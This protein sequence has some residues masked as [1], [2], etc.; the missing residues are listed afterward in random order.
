VVQGRVGIEHHPA[1]DGRLIRPATAIAI[2]AMAML[3]ASGCSSGGDGGGGDGDDAGSPDP[4]ASKSET[5]YEAG[6]IRGRVAGLDVDAEVTLCGARPAPPDERPY[7]TLQVDAEGTDADG[8]S[9]SIQVVQTVLDV[10]NAVVETIS[11]RWGEITWEAQRVHDNDTGEVHDLHGDG[12]TPLL[13]IDESDDA[14]EI[15]TTAAY[16]QFSFSEDV[17][18]GPAGDGSLMIECI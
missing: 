11:I 14:L 17:E 10:P 13:E 18:D 5:L 7:N 3:L 8:D 9:Y 15:A 16:Y 4:T 6:H 2:A 12:T 1:E